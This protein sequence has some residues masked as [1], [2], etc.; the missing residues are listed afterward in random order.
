MT[1]VARDGFVERLRVRMSGRLQPEPAQYIFL[2][3]PKSGRTWVRFMIDSYL[4]KRYGRSVQNVFAAEKD[5]VTLRHHRIKFTHLMGEEDLNYYE[6]GGFKHRTLV[7]KSH[8]VLL[9][10]NLYATLWTQEFNKWVKVPG[11]LPF[12][13]PGSR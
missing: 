11:V 9:T 6:L 10:R 12:K 4:V 5:P 7:P 1:L 2:S 3:Y 8:A 13:A